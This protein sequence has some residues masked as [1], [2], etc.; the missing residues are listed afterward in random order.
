MGI[1]ASEYRQCRV[2]AW[3]VASDFAVISQHGSKALSYSSGAE[4]IQPL[5]SVCD[6]T[7]CGGFSVHPC[8]LALLL[9]AASKPCL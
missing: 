7:S 5:S 4:S 9:N 6:L 2:S 8:I 3:P 1:F